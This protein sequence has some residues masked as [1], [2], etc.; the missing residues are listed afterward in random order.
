M[1]NTAL[2]WRLSP[3][4]DSTGADS[5]HSLNPN[6]CNRGAVMQTKPKVGDAVEWQTSQ[7]ETTGKVV[8]KV[9]RTAHVKGHVAKASPA[10]PQYEVKSDKTGKTAIH[11]ADALKHH[12]PGKG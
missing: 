4:P 6:I 3:T 1:D 10:E 2:D 11:K 12:S 7:G 8:R 9:S 5:L